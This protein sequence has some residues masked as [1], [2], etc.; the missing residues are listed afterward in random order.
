MYGI[1][2]EDME[3]I[4]SKIEKQ[5]QFL[6]NFSI[7]FADKSVN[8]LDNT[9]SANLNPKKYFAEI[10]N[11]VNSL[12]DYA[13]DNGLRPVF[14]T[15][16]APSKYHKK[17]RFGNYIENPN[18]TAKA[19]TQIWNKFTN[20]Q[21]FQKMK[22]ELNH[23]LVY[24]RVY[25]PHKS[26]VPH[27]HAMLFIPSRYI[28]QVK[29][30]YKEYFSSS[31]WG[32]N[33]K[34]I[35]FRY[36][37][38]KEKGGPVGYIMKYITKTFKDE[39]SMKVEHAIYWYIKHKIRR[40]L[41]S[42]TLAPLTIYR[43]VRYYF[44]EQYENDFKAVTQM[45]KDGTIRRLFNN[46]M[47]YYIYYNHEIGE[48]DEVYIWSKNAE[49]IL[50]QRIENKKKTIKLKY[51]KKEVKKPLKATISEFEEYIYSDIQKAFIKLPVI[52]SAL[53]DYKL[54]KYHRLL[55]EMDIKDLDLAHFQIVK[56]EM[57]RRGL[58]L[59]ERVSP[60]EF[61]EYEQTNS[62]S[63]LANVPLKFCVAEEIDYDVPYTASVQGV[64]RCY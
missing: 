36:T 26:G 41:S 2:N 54:S 16:T 52:P 12:F 63:A 38:Y 24:F 18:D 5:K 15:L 53:S 30:K 44:K 40:F 39:N 35:D 31:K 59:E 64:F 10:N 60:N 28:L 25:E 43:K 42:R 4:E 21:V 22:K 61:L 7:D 57:I 33:K 27:L 1:T 14:V 48:I 19:L 55:D 47:I 11:R 46:T 23:G 37:W 3:Y 6:K 13:K 50:N 49:S 51:Q 32:S 58:L 8:M 34:A 20:L 45:L 29:K 56:N 62:M 17:D 9:Y